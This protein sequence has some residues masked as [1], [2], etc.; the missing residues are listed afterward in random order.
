MH[1]LTAVLA[2][3]TRCTIGMPISAVKR[4][5]TVTA[6][7]QMI[8]LISNILT[9]TVKVRCPEV[10]AVSALGYALEL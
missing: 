4:I 10:I 9:V 2:R 5:V 8:A 6:H 1:T 3:T 7:S